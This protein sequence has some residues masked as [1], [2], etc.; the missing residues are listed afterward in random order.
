LFVS[1]VVVRS[2]FPSAAV[3]SAIASQLPSS[4]NRRHESSTEER[5]RSAS[6]RPMDT[7]HLDTPPTAPGDR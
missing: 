4:R 3:S 5:A 7:R 6:R 2:V 1:P